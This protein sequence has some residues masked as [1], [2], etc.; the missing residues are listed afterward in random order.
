MRTLNLGILAHV[1]AG[2]T[3]LT[4]RLLFHAGVIKTLG[5]VDTGDTQ[6]D[7]LQL[8]RDRGITIRSAVASFSARGTRI[9]LLDTPGHPDFIAE[10][11]RVLGVLD[12]AVLVISAVEGVQAQTR[13]LMRALARLKVPTVIFVNKVDRRGADGGAALANLRDRLTTA[14]VPMGSV[15][16]PGTPL[17]SFDPGAWHDRDFRAA[18]LQALAERD[19]D[20]LAAFAED[21]VVDAGTLR[22]RLARQTAD[23]LIFPVYF[24]SAITGAGIEE[25]IDGITDLLPAPI[26][27]KDGPVSAT[28]FKVERNAAGEKL[29]LLRVVSGALRVRDRIPIAHKENRVTDIEIFTEGRVRR[30]DVAQAGDIARVKGLSDIKV[31]DWIGDRANAPQRQFAPPMLEAA[32][33]PDDKADAPALWKALSQLSEQDPLINLRQ[34]DGEDGL[35]ISLYGEVQ[36]EVIEHTLKADYGLSVRFLDTSPIYVERILGVGNA[37]EHAP[38]PFLATIGLRVEASGS[39]GR[40]R[41]I[42]EVEPG[43]AP[44]FAFK[45]IDEALEAAFGQG[46]HG[47]QVIN[48]SVSITEITRLR[49]WTTSTPSD[50]RNLTPLVLAQALRIA[51]TEVCEPIDRITIDM[52]AD[53]LPRVQSLLMRLDAA[54]EPPVARGEM[55]MLSGTIAAINVHDIQ[56]ALPSL[57]SGLG[58]METEFF[59]YRPVRGAAP[60]RRRSG[61]NPFSRSE[62]LAQLKGARQV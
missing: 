30:S 2:K 59:G 14:L 39:E 19:D 22:E 34:G 33:L 15:S 38:D 10:V 61:P 50:H 17:A 31:G 45:A 26:P 20:L 44:P 13:V 32:I 51:G 25:L 3:S 49:K 37:I 29:A 60:V 52:P 56:R 43:A 5:G 23:G 18:V 27:P 58:T 62:Y 57:T 4:E 46:I 8:E 7:T 6:T 9:N 11:E 35:S 47:W 12:G 36:K 53:A 24:G 28:V 55:M 40:H 21:R 54:L 1:D 16:A 41:L 48:A 42:F